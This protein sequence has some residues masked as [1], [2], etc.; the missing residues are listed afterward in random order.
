MSDEDNPW[1]RAKP[2]PHADKRERAIAA[3]PERGARDDAPRPA[4][5]PHGGAPAHRE[6][7][8]R[9]DA[10]R[11]ERA[12]REY[13]PHREHALRP[14]ASARSERAPAPQASAHDE[15]AGEHAPRRNADEVRIYGINACR[16]AFAARPDDLRK[17]YLLDTRMGALRDVLAWCVKHKLGYRVVET[18][19]LDKL[20]ASTHHEGVVFEMKRAKQPTLAQLLDGLGAGAHL[21]LWLDGVGNPHNFGAVLRSA[22]H[23]G[24]D[25]VL[26][27]RS[28]TLTVSGAAARVAEGGAEVVPVV[29]L[30]SSEQA[31]ALLQS[32]GFT[33]AATLPR[34]AQSIYEAQLPQ[35]LV[36][37]FGAEGEG[38]QPAL[39]GASTL[40]LAIPGSGRVESLNIANA[41]GVMLGEWWR[42][43]RS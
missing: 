31:V 39:V 26:L 15:G 9:P 33:I 41:V 43:H 2:K 40:Q 12:S 5:A 24:V 3:R 38:L 8:P 11:T 4:R 14:G 10:P 17:V 13:P 18:Q 32:H 20:A 7:A 1:S 6:S 22:A 27:P 23:F 30:E 21:L 42:R 35:R 16:A 19:D 34:G 37:V 25:A 29:A 28:S 36:L